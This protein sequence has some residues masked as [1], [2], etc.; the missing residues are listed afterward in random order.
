M[1][2]V[3]KDCWSKKRI[4][5][6]N[7]AT[8]KKLEEEWDAEVSFTLDK[9]ELALIATTHKQ[10]DYGND[11]IVDSSYSNYM[12]GGAKKL[13]N[14]EEYKG[15]HVV[16]TTSNSK[17]LIAHIGNVTVSP[18]YGNVKSDAPKCI[19]CSWHEG[20]SSLSI[21]VDIF[22]PFC[23]VWSTRCENIPRS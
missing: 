2:H 20:K 11:W 1:G 10:A 3:A 8:S 6:S 9:S 17:L 12:T 14:V 22:W 19:S 5:E 21:T 13:Q 23:P 7:A 15:S 16:V 4:V 18:Q